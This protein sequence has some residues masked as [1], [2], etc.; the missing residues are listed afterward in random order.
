M[1]YSP[2]GHIESD[3]TEAT[4]IMSAHIYVNPNLPV[5]PTLLPPLVALMFIG[6]FAF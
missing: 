2:W 1:G 6:P 3:T 5:H 4:S